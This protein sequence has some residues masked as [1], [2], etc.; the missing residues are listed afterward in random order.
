MN[1]FNRIIVILLLITGMVL[2][3]LIFVFPD[4]AIELA[5]WNLSVLEANLALI[6]PLARLIGGLALAVLSF[7]L[8][9]VL[10]F[11]EF[12][13]FRPKAV[14]VSQV[15]G[16]EA[17]LA[18]ESI[19]SRLQY[20]VSQ[21]GDVVSV[22]PKVTVRGK[23]IRVEINLETNP[24]INVPAKIEEVCEVVRQTVE[25]QMGLKLNKVKV[26]IKHARVPLPLNR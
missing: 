24:E 10:L 19:A 22:K 16:G 20:N 8:C 25:E 21:L 26:N 14:R 15:A 6:N 2:S 11:L 4:R 7:L 18:L 13:R 12:A 17:S 5:H 9:L 23:G 1:L 3:P